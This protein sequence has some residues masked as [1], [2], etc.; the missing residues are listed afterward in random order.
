METAKILKK[1]VLTPGNN[2]IS[3]LNSAN[4]IKKNAVTPVNFH[5]YYYAANNPVRYTDPTGL[6]SIDEENHT[7]T[8]DYNDEKDLRAAYKEFKKNKTLNECIIKDFNK[9]GSVVIKDR[10]ALGRIVSSEALT[11]NLSP[12]LDFTVLIP[13]GVA[14][15]QLLS[16]AEAVKQL[17]LIFSIIS[18]GHDAASAKE[19]FKDGNI[20][21]GISYTVDTVFDIGSAVNVDVYLVFQGYKCTKFMVKGVVYGIKELAKGS[22][23]LEHKIVNEC[24]NFYTGKNWIGW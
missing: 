18:V 8:C 17:G 13:D 12:L 11:K 7:I 16:K 4:L 9:E 21:K 1:S 2:R 19:A 24:A 3:L 6:F 20:L 5:L 22:V 14:L 10:K 15:L 23:Y